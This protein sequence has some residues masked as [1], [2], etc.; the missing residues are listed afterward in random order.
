MATAAQR[1]KAVTSEVVL[2]DMVEQ[3]ALQVQGLVASAKAAREGLFVFGT[4]CTDGPAA[5]AAAPS[6]IFASET[7]RPGG[8]VQK[9]EVLDRKSVV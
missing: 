1:A 6:D 2:E 9:P 4:A 8:L 3:A 7:Q 5:T